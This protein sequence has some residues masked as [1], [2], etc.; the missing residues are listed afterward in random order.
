MNVSKLYKLSVLAWFIGILPFLYSKE[1]S[2]GTITADQIMKRH[3]ERNAVDA[4]TQ[5]VTIV[6][7][8]GEGKVDRHALFFAT[9]KNNDRRYEYLIRVVSP[10]A[11]S[12][13][14]FLGKR[15]DDNQLQRYL[16]LPAFGKPKR[17][18]S[19]DQS[20]RFLNSN[21]N[22]RDII[23]EDPQEYDYEL[24]GENTIRG[25]EVYMLNATQNS[26]GNEEP[27]AY[28]KRHLYID[29]KQY[30]ILKIDFFRQND[31]QKPSKTLNAYDYDSVLVDGETMRPRRAEMRDHENGTVSVMTV[32]RSEFNESIEENIF[33]LENLTSWNKEKKKSFLKHFN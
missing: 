6:T 12:G 26:D 22:Y 17:I 30:N 19:S 13:V 8:H 20:S 7:V 1:E 2:D 25:Q 5:F 31:Q 29:R 32:V 18:S 4:E 9:R 3:I 24:L 16:Y 11:Q 23:R 27:S 14:S 28:A 21:F 33:T 10:K 15:N